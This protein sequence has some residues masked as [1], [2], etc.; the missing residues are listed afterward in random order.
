MNELE[1]QYIE[2]RTSCPWVYERFK[3]LAE[4][5]IRLNR[6]F[7]MQALVERVRWDIQLDISKDKS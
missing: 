1:R 2:W 3:Q 5:R 6:K 7:G 4:D